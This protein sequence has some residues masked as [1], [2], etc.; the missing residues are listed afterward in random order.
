MQDRFNN[1]QS[2]H[3]K[4]IRYYLYLIMGQQNILQRSSGLKLIL[5]KCNSTQNL[6][7]ACP[8]ELLL[9]LRILYFNAI[10]TKYKHDT[11]YPV[12]TW[13]FSVPSL[14]RRDSTANQAVAW[15][16][17]LLSR[18]LANEN[19]FL[20][21]LCS[22]RDIYNVHKILNCSADISLEL[23]WPG[24]PVFYMIVSSSFVPLFLPSCQIT[25]SRIFFASFLV[26]LSS[27]SSSF[28]MTSII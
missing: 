15:E 10:P 22:R 25:F 17:T 5:L 9:T 21:Q 14:G 28:S 23:F 1:L 12:Y 24:Y 13:F 26:H 11:G 2:S 4:Q 3:W 7:A 16:N 18:F 20:L 19:Y 8:F 6:E 27:S